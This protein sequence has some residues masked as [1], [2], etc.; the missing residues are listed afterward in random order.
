M[1]GKG[2]E[3]A[4][5]LQNE[6]VRFIFCFLGVFVCYFYYG[7]LQETI[8]RGKYG[9]GDAREK[10]RYATTLV[11]IQCI[12]NAAFAKCLIQF[13]ERPKADHTRSWLYV[14]CSLSYLGAMVS[15]NSA[16]LYVNYP[17]QVCSA[18]PQCTSHL[19]PS[20]TTASPCVC[21]TVGHCAAPS[22][23]PLSD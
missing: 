16:L 5:L 4:S 8:T 23:S 20:C 13:F 15:S 7:I 2:S 9:E 6:R 1:A 17:T 21:G 22:Y 19:P 12:I 14:A 18:F 11:F 3:K 10:F